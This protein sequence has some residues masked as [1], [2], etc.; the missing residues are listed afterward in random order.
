MCVSVNV[1]ECVCVC[2]YICV[3]VYCVCV[4]VWCDCVC[5]SVSMCYCERE[6]VCVCVSMIRWVICANKEKEHNDTLEPKVAGSNPAEAV[7]FFRA[8]KSPARLPSEG[9]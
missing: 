2:V 6:R 9:K 7:G 3:C 5:V 4:C 1:H 8:K